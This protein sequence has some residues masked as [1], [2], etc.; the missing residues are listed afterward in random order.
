MC[1][2][3]ENG[4]K[5]YEMGGPGTEMTY[6]PNFPPKVELLIFLK[7]PPKSAQKVT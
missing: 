5:S 2:V 6:F 3:S 4:Q 1:T 7:I